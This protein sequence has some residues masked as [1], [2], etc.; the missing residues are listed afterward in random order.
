M[1]GG[2][3]PTALGQGAEE[4]IPSDGDRRRFYAIAPPLLPRV[5]EARGYRSVA[6][7]NNFF[8][9]GYPQIGLTLGLR[10]GRRHPPSGAR[11]A[12]DQQ[13]RGRVHRGASRRALVPA[14]A[15]RRAALA[16]HA[17]AGVPGEGARDAVPRRCD[18][19]RVPRRGGLRRRLPR[20]RHRRARS[21]EAVGATRWSSSSAITARSSTTRTPRPSRR[22][23][24]RRCTIT[25]GRGTTS[26]CAC[27][28]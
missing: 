18:G 4:M 25:A 20:A 3:L 8:L 6:I 14:S 24:S 1:L 28:W 7:G 2:D 11:H 15:L 19:A 26:C 27:R 21:A 13:R 16:V 12:G 9:L 22:C 23:I 17:A 5:L 10:G